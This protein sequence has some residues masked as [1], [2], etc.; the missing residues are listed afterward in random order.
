MPLVSEIF[1]PRRF[2]RD[3]EQSRRDGASE[4]VLAFYREFIRVHC[5]GELLRSIPASEMQDRRGVDRILEWRTSSGAIQYTKVQEKLRRKTF[6]DIALEYQHRFH[7][8]GHYESGWICKP[9]TS[10][11]TAYIRLP[12]RNGVVF[13]SVA[14]HNIWLRHAPD[15]LA[16]Y[17]HDA[18]SENPNY[19]SISCCVPQ[20]ALIDLIG[21]EQVRVIGRVP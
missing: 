3:L 14:L 16:D 18:E 10:T 13:D 17:P 11:I 5:A 9:P 15:L 12:A 20:A 2:D 8:D 6:G 7:R 1:G 21:A 19:T 4:L